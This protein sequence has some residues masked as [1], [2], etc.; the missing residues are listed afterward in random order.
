MIAK[1]RGS[2]DN[3]SGV[4]IEKLMFEVSHIMINTGARARWQVG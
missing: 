2:L 1:E 4:S 3:L